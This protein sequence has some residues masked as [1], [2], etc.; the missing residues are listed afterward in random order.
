[1]YLSSAL[2]PTSKSTTSICTR[3]SLNIAEA[4]LLLH[5]TQDTARSLADNAR[6]DDTM[7]CFWSYN[8]ARIGLKHHFVLHLAYA[9]AAYHIAYLDPAN[10]PK[11]LE[12][13]NLAKHHA[14]LGLP[15]LT[16]ALARIDNDNCGA[17][18][19]AAT[20]VCYC[21]FAAGPTGPGD[22][23]VCNLDA[24]HDGAWLPLIYGV[25]LIRENFDEDVLFAGLMEP[26]L[27]NKSRSEAKTS[28]LETRRRKARCSQESFER[29]NWEEP[30]EKLRNFVASRTFEGAE[31]C[32]RGL[33]G[34]V[35]I[36]A[37]TYGDR[38]ATFDGPSEDQF[39][40]GWLYRLENLFISCLR[41]ENSIALVILAYY[42]VLLRTME[43]LWYMKG[44]AD[45]L[46]ATVRDLVEEEYYMWLHWPTE[47][48]QHR[49]T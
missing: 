31:T 49:E 48:Q 41:Q 46:L 13:I 29:L 12:Y 38:D 47:S 5:F 11:K 18:Y 2:S 40:F 17:A 32:L 45:Y 20:L 3:N 43:H 16:L 27:G 9:L 22:L 10:S 4:E 37:A 21:T 36:Y 26:F 7:F 24:T 42:A 19:I 34:M 14:S 30:L 1:M 25:R 28:S 33:D 6:P 8:L 35:P 15:Q 44:W 39:V 23:L